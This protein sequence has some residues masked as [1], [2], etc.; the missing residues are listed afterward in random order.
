MPEKTAKIPAKLELPNGKTIEIE[1]PPVPK[2]FNAFKRD[3]GYLYAKDE[4]LKVPTFIPCHNPDCRGRG[5]IYD[6]NEQPCPV[7]G[8]KMRSR[9]KCTDCGGTGCGSKK[10]LQ[11]IHRARHTREAE[12][13]QE[14]LDQ[15]EKAK[16]SLQKLSKTLTAQEWENLRALRIVS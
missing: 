8:N 14:K 4:L 15:V 11:E 2:S 7:E 1:L 9:L 6:P 13:R 12:I 3:W 16:K 10:K 5:W